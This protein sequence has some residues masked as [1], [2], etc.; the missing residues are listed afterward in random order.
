MDISYLRMLKYSFSLTLVFLM[1]CQPDLDYNVKGY[2]QKIIVEA[3]I[4]EGQSPVVRL[5]LNNPVW[6]KVD[7]ATILQNVIRY[8][9]VTVSD[10]DEAEVLT[11]GWDPDHF[12]PYKYF[13][14]SL[15]GKAGH[16]YA[17]SVEYSGYVVRSTTTIPASGKILSFNS[18]VVNT[19][20]SLRNLFMILDMGS[21]HTRGYRVFSHNLKDKGFNEVNVV[22]NQDLSLSGTH[23]YMIIPSV[24]DKD[25]SHSYS[26]YYKQGDTVQIR[27]A[28][29]DSVSTLFFRGLTMFSSSTGIAN[30]FFNTEKQKLASNVSAPGFGIWCGESD[31]Y[32]Q[33]IVP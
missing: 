3:S 25:K 7:S 15:I 27:L 9:K 10:G 4:I 13:G 31:R 21:D 26:P 8:A 24:S 30:M 18:E 28:T 23:R 20:D 29:I 6:N 17:L 19:K 11:S 5:S 1:A 12:P 22:Y 2:T 32:Y 14:T 16:T 33:Y